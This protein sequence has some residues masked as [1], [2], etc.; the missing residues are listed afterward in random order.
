MSILDGIVTIGISPDPIS[1]PV[2]EFSFM[3]MWNPTVSEI[4]E[5]IPFLEKNRK[6]LYVWCW[7]Y[8]DDPEYDYSRVYSSRVTMGMWL[9]DTQQQAYDLYAKSFKHLVRGTILNRDWE[10]KNDL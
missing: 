5:L 10:F 1:I 8:T 3:E 9:G 4:K 7:G 6:I 2:P